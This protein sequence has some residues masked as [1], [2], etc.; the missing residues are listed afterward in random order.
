M[1][2]GGQRFALAGLL[3][4]REPVPIFTGGWLGLKTGLESY[5]KFRPYRD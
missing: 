2:V 3:P 4:E 1:E 5:G